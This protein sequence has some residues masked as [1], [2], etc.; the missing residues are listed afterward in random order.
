ME[1]RPATDADIPAIVDLL[2]ISLGEDGT[3]KTESY[4][5]WKHI[6][7]PFGQSPVLLAFEGARLIGIRA[8]M[9]WKWQSRSQSLESVRAV[10]TATHPDFRGKGTFSKLTLALL[11]KCKANGW[12]FVF[13]TPN[14]ISKAGYMKMGWTQAGRLPLGIRLRHPLS[15]ALNVVGIGLKAAKR[16]VDTNVGK[17]LRHPSLDALITRNAGHCDDSLITAHTSRSLTWRY[18]DVTVKQYY[19]TAV[20][21]GAD[22]RALA[23]YRIKEGRIGTEFRITDVF[24]DEP[25]TRRAL[26]EAIRESVRLHDADYVT[27]GASNSWIADVT[28]LGVAKVAVGPTVTVRNISGSY[29]KLLHNFNQWQPSVGDLE[30]F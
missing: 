17:Y 21:S 26:R 28:M 29:E 14:K 25:N 1:I 9:R 27:V 4:W 10:D 11:E 5:R 3:A 16:L 13:N 15:I 12:D 2:K 6:E 19:A 8:F 23:F 18:H 20:E 22:L 7:N 30:L 24:V